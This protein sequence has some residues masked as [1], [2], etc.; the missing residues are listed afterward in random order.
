MTAA[1]AVGATISSLTLHT[2]KGNDYAVVCREE[3]G[4]IDVTNLCKAGGR[5]YETWNRR[6]ATK[7]FVLVL[8]EELQNCRADIPLELVKFDT[9]DTQRTWAHPRVALNIAQW[10]SPAFD[11]QVTKWVHQLLVTGHVRLTDDPDDQ[12]LLDIQIG[13][14]KY[15]RLL[16]EGNVAEAEVAKNEAYKQLEEMQA[17][18]AALAET[19]AELQEENKTA[20][21]ENQRLTK[22]LQRQPRTQYNKGDC[23]YIVK[24][25]AYLNQYKVG[26]TNNMTDRMGQYN[27]SSPTEFVMV[28]LVYTSHN[29]W[30]EKEIKRDHKDSRCRTNRE[31]YEFEGGPSALIDTISGYL[32][33]KRRNTGVE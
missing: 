25:P 10:V 29:T 17:K 7:E 8:R 30:L 22:Y 19:V 26:I 11:V 33:T 12:T 27:T 28:H 18:N 2:D 21:A 3:D 31:W 9:G 14:A 4:Y 15:A 20:F 5:K 13:R 16:R 32:P 6:K 24:N 1:A 23:I